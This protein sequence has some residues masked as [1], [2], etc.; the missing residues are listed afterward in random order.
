MISREPATMHTGLLAAAKKVVALQD[1]A[2]RRDGDARHAIH[3]LSTAI[4]NAECASPRP[5]TYWILTTVWLFGFGTG[6]VATVL[7]RRAVQ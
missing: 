4:F 6:V 3:A 5:S 7:L 1:E 2:S